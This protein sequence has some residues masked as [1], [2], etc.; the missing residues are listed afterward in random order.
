MPFKIFLTG[1]ATYLK[2]QMFP[3]ALN[4]FLWTAP[5]QSIIFNYMTRSWV[6]NAE[7]STEGWGGV[8]RTLQTKLKSY[9]IWWNKIYFKIFFMLENKYIWKK[10][11]LEKFH[12]QGRFLM[13]WHEAPVFFSF[14][15]GGGGARK[16]PHHFALL[17]LPIKP[18]GSLGEEAPTNARF[19]ENSHRLE[20]SVIGTYFSEPRKFW[21]L[22][23]CFR[24]I[25]FA[26]IL[27]SCYQ[28]SINKTL[29]IKTGKKLA[30]AVTHNKK[31]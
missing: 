13:S 7:G 20:S 19:L 10:K 1:I 14:A 11:V 5:L 31:N 22:A 23:W 6:W 28:Y 21:H 9:W 18:C 12:R 15:D 26:S 27:S 30:Y 2:N 3:Q 8:L 16:P 29:T 24:T 4:C 17:N 25:L